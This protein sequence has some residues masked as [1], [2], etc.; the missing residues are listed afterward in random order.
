MLQREGFN[1]LGLELAN[2]KPGGIDREITPLDVRR[3]ARV[4]FFRYEVNDHL[5]PPVDFEQDTVATR[6]PSPRKQCRWAWS[7]RK[8]RWCSASMLGVV[9]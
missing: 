2:A 9:A 7:S 1:W 8:R 3:Q 4:L 6:P 5:F